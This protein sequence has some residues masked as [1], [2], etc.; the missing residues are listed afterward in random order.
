LIAQDAEGQRRLDARLPGH[1]E[2]AR[3]RAGAVRQVPAAI[4]ARRAEGA[5]PWPAAEALVA[6]AGEVL[7]AGGVLFLY[8]PF[9]RFGR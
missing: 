4:A 8:G 7:G 3:V 6:G 2:Q 9:R 5:A 1:G